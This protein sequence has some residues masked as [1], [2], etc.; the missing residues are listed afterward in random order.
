MC[1]HPDEPVVQ[2]RYATLPRPLHLLAV[3]HWFVTYTPE[4]GR[5][6]RWEVWQTANAGGTSWVHVHRNLMHPDRGVGGGPMRIEREWR[7]D[8]A[9][10]LIEVLEDPLR[11]PY[12][13]RYRAWPGPNSNTYAVWALRQAGLAHEFD[14]R[15]VGK[16]YLGRYGVGLVTSGSL[17]QVAS[18]LA[19]VRFERG[20]GAEVQ[21][22]CLTFGV[23]AGPVVKTP[24]GSLRLRRQ[25]R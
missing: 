9:R 3:H 20:R 12:R 17:L 24:V 19:G 4:I 16:D 15:A 2:L 23:G 10:R 25:G 7:G 13:D 18:P 6:E 8:D 5:W 22:L 1:Q 14:P 21:L 11:Y